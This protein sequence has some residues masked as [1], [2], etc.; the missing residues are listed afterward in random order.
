MM[1]N[2]GSVTLLGPYYPFQREKVRVLNPKRRLVETT[3][4]PLDLPV[5]IRC[6][7][8]SHDMPQGSNIAAV[9][10]LA[11]PDIKNSLGDPIV[12]YQ[13]TCK[14]CNNDISLTEDSE[15]PGHIIVGHGGTQIVEHDKSELLGE[16][17]DEDFLNYQRPL[18][19]LKKSGHLRHE[20]LLDQ[21]MTSGSD[22]KR[23]K[24][25][26]GL[27]CNPTTLSD[28]SSTISDGS[29]TEEVCDKP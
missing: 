29:S 4:V 20:I 28:S 11:N 9:W 10:R 25:M 16:I 7:G 13:L 14:E 6:N 3:R 1:K 19:N 27:P 12:S 15:N 22:L 8:C 26:V 24:L 18:I 2:F 23:Q 17:V 5:S 21:E